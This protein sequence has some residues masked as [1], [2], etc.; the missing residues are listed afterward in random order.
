MD[1]KYKNYEPTQTVF[2]TFDPGEYF[3]IGSFERF[4]VDTIEELDLSNFIKINDKASPPSYDPRAI[5]GI[6]FYSYCLGCFSAR[7]MEKNCK[8]NMGYMYI[9]GHNTPEHTTISRFLNKY[10]EQIIELFT[11]ILY[12]A[13]RCGYINYALI[14]VDGTKIKAKSSERF[15]GTI[16]DFKKRKKRLEEKI[17]LAIE[18]QRT[19]E[20]DD[21]KDYW[22]KKEEAFK[23]DKG[24]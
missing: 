18:K 2:F 23:K 3:P 9:S 7:T 11:K 20:A 22:S 17:K 15:I 21:K 12:I 24:I 5:I 10:E 16:K 1:K 6:L 8:Y 13:D 4:L 19:A 14:A